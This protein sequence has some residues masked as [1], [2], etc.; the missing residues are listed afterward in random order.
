GSNFSTGQCQLLCV[1]RA[2]LKQSKILMI[3]E[4]TANVDQTTDSLIQ[5]V[6]AEKFKD[7]TILTIAHRLNTVAKS[8]RI[9]VMHQGKIL[10]F[11]VPQNILPKYGHEQHA[12]SDTNNQS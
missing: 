2:I 4:A 12:S 10:D 9:I 3:D 5:N 11:D 1:A 6:I 8:D 7:R